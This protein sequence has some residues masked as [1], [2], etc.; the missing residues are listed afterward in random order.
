M[1]E[2]VKASMHF[3]GGSDGSR[4]VRSMAAAATAHIDTS[5]FTFILTLQNPGTLPGCL[6]PLAATT[7]RTMPS[8][9]TT[10]VSSSPSSV[11]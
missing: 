4:S 10:S 7:H 1:P 2:D 5:L 8:W 11:F 9:K 6:A 3:M